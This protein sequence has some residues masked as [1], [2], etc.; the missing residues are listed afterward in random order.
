MKAYACNLNSRGW[1]NLSICLLHAFPLPTR[2]AASAPTSL[3]RVPQESPSAKNFS[4]ASCLRPDCPGHTNVFYPG[5]ETQAPPQHDSPTSLGPKHTDSSKDEAMKSTF[6]FFRFGRV[7]LVSTVPFFASSTPADFEAL[8]QKSRL[9]QFRFVFFQER[10][11]SF[12][13]IIS[14]ERNID[15]VLNRT[16]FGRVHPQSIFLC[17]LFS[18]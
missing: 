7:P 12:C 1:W 5:A 9:F 16:G 15:I 2:R 18:H 4:Q 8:R 11:K 3:A 14:S 6:P 17:P 10:L 13:Q